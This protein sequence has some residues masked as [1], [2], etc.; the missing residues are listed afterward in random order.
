M[1]RFL[2]YYNPEKEP[3]LLKKIIFDFEHSIIKQSYSESYTPGLNYNKL[4][5]DLNADGFGIGWFNNLDKKFY[6]YKNIQPI[7]NDENLNSLANNIK[8][9][10]VLTHIRANLFGLFAPVSLSNTHPFIIDDFIWMH[11]GCIINFLDKKEEII[12]LINTN[13]IKKIK[14]STDSEYCF[15][16]FL[17]FYYKLNNPILAFKKIFSLFKKLNLSSYLNF[18]VVSNEFF[19]VTRVGINNDKDLLSLYYN[20]K[21]KIIS[22]EPLEKDN[23]DWKIVPENNIIFYDQKTKEQSFHHIDFDINI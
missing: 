5:A 2:V 19:I 17:S 20:N 14:G 8:S 22:S 9:N 10:I 1:C 6:K 16:L 11:N 23:I 13:L 12:N 18:V 4:N 3:I 15:A 21:L 7:W